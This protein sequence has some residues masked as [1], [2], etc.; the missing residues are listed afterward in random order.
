MSLFLYDT[1]L[2]DGAQ[3]EGLSFSVADKLKLAE[4]LADFGVHYIEGGFPGSNPKDAEFFQLAEKR[5]WAKTKLVA[6][7]ATRHKNFSAEKDPNLSGVLLSG[8]RIATIFGKTWDFHAEQILNVSLNENLTLIY[9]SIAFLKKRGLRVIFDAEHFFDGFKSNSGY[10]L[11]CLKTA[12]EAGAEN[13]SLCDTN[14]GAMPEEVARAVSI[15]RKKLDGEEANFQFPIKSKIQNHRKAVSGKPSTSPLV[16]KSISTK[17]LE[18]LGTHGLITIPNYSELFRTNSNFSQ[19]AIGIHAHDDCGLAIANT[20]AA[21]SAGATLIHGTINGYGERV[22]NANL[23]TLIPLLQIKLGQK[24]FPPKYLRELTALSH[25][26]AEVANLAPPAKAPFVGT[27]AFTHKAGV[28]AAAVAKLPKS[29]EH[30]DPQVVG[31]VSRVT[32]SELSGRSN[33]LLLARALGVNLKKDAPLTAEILKRVKILEAEGFAFEGAEGSFELLLLRAHK[34]YRPP[35]ELTDYSVATR[36]NGLDGA[37]IEATVRV[38]IK[39]QEI[40]TASLGNGPVN[41][42]DQALRKALLPHFPNLKKVTLFDYKV[43]ILNPTSATAAK[44]RVLIESGDGKKRWSTV[45]C[46]ENIIEASA[47]A[48]VDALE[49]GIGGSARYEGRSEKK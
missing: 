5:P 44:T 38:K 23:C 13:L 24:I 27:N 21:I 15:V 47:M 33:V 14:G 3:Q 6:F 12:A 17:G 2:R 29:Y 28:H 40:H 26:F 4:K 19:S 45:G 48:L 31:N 30:I 37:K 34:N 39:N 46:S 11:D 35:F 36:H 18:D 43:R 25:L 32:V 20:L 41:A 16:L 1:T 42:L 10:A 8:A 49:L 7:T 22:G 9:D